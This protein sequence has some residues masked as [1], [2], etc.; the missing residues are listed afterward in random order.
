ML[1]QAIVSHFEKELQLLLFEKRGQLA[2]PMKPLTLFFIERVADYHP[3][4]AKLRRW[5]GDEY[6]SIR[7]DARFRAVAPQMPPVDEV[8]GG[9]FAEAKK[10]VPKEAKALHQGSRRSVRADHEAQGGAPRF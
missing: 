10:G 4:D 5:F 9:Y 1:R 8:H 6:E 3:D 7:S 2:A